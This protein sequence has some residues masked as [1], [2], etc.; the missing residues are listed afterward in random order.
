M[1]YLLSVGATNIEDTFS[2]FVMGKY[3]IDCVSKYNVFVL[4]RVNYR[5][6]KLDSG[7]MD[8]S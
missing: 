6:M 7:Q 8:I 3:F 5:T 4:E 2:N 1:L